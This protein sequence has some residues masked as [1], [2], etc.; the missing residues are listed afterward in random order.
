VI[1]VWILCAY[2]LAP[3]LRSRHSARPTEHLKCAWV[4][5]RQ[6]HGLRYPQQRMRQL[7]GPTVC[8]WSAAK[9]AA[10]GEHQFRSV[11][12]RRF[13]HSSYE[14]AEW[15]GPS[16]LGQ[17]AHAVIT[18][19]SLIGVV[20]CSDT[21]WPSKRAAW[22]S[23]GDWRLN[24]VNLHARRNL[25]T[26]DATTVDRQYSVT[27]ASAQRPAA[28]TIRSEKMTTNWW[29]ECCCCCT[30]L[31]HSV[32]CWVAVSSGENVTLKEIDGLRH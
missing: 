25:S 7:I 5:Y 6:C 3:S 28:A 10:I 26:R 8:G 31:S 32:G 27:A 15:K 16:P 22:C 24:C 9:P 19:I 20:S 29:N 2:L 1:A 11:P 12:H 18:Q 14:T 23:T 30:Q 4:W 13:R 17:R 21:V